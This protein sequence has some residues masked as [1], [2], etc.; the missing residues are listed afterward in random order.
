MALGEADVL[1]V[2]LRA[3]VYTGTVLAAGAV[4]F[5]LTFPALATVL[6]ALRRQIALGAVLLIICEPLRYILFQLQIAGGDFALALSPSM[7]WIGLETPLG[8]AALVR[9]A[10]LAVVLAAGLRFRLFGVAAAT[11]MIGAYLVEGHTAS[12]EARTVLAPLL[13]VHLVA[14]HWWIGALPPL[15]VAA[16]SSPLDTLASTLQRFGAIALW[17]V[18]LLAAGGVVL[19]VVLTDW[20]MNFAAAYQQAFALKLGLVGLILA[21][22]ALNRLRI[23][24]QLARHDPAGRGTLKT[25]LNVELIVAVAILCASALVTAF[26]P[27]S[28]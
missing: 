19:L 21:I 25:S 24:P 14:V 22:A 1:A 20:R 9:L 13:F 6:P 26:P 16:S 2:L 8:Q 7:R 3:L 23:T 27:T 10:G 4:L 28:E 15:R 12:D 11:V 17:G 18:G 5:R